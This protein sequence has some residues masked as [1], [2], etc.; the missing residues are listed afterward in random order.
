MHFAR[1]ASK[2]SH[3][4]GRE[5]CGPAGG[6]VDQVRVGHQRRTLDLTVPPSPLARADEVIE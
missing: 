5:A 3:P 6:A 4:Q 2:R 1:S